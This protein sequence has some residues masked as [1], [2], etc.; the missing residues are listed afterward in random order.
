VG[1]TGIG[2]SR[3]AYELARELG[4]EIV[5]ADSRQ[6]YRG[7]DIATN[8]P[9]PGWRREVAYH[10]IDLV[11][12]TARFN[13]AEWVRGAA[14]AVEE[15]AGRGRLPIVEG[16]TML[17]VDALAD[18][19][20]L[21][22]VPAD[23]ALR[24]RLEL[25]STEDLGRRLRQL[26]PGAQVDFRNRV[27]LVRAIE[28]LEALGPPLARLRQRR[29]PAWEAIRIGV[30]APRE[31]IDQRLSER[32][33]RQVE[34]GLVEETRRALESGVA[35]DAPVMT[36][37]GYAE[38][39]A[40]LRGEISFEALPE[41]MARSNRRYARRQLTWLRRDGRIHWFQAEPDP[42]PAILSFL[43]EHLG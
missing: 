3:I 36:G 8:K 15:I 9:D 43:K 39:I 27:R 24:R 4:G 29:P 31:V 12:P 35:P 10:M 19:F 17:Y 25:L 18:G 28:L 38:A 23:P 5:V 40:H 11:P 7:L 32:S 2:K 42:A 16:G 26:D 33:R 21:A 6:V 34:R 20:T 14:Q 30:T 1:P 22:G 13:A 37:I 41:A